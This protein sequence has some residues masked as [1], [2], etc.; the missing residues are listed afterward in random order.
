M[1]S[2]FGQCPVDPGIFFRGASLTWSCNPA[3]RDQE[4]P[5]KGQHRLCNENINAFYEVCDDD[6]TEKNGVEYIQHSPVQLAEL[7][8][9]NFIF[10]K[11]WRVSHSWPD[12]NHLIIKMIIMMIVMIVI[13]I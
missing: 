5:A 6:E 3:M 1:Q 2:P 13:M 7:F 8:F 9:G 11:R 12:F 4:P 10:A